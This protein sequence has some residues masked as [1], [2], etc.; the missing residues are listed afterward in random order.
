VAEQA[1]DGFNV[2]V[3][4]TNSGTTDGDEVTQVYISRTGTT[5]PA[6]PLAL[7]AFA[8]TPV[9][10]GK[11]VLLSLTVR[12]A[13]LAVVQP[14][15]RQGWVLQPCEITLYVGGRQPSAPVPEHNPQDVVQVG[16]AH[17]SHA[18]IAF[19]RLIGF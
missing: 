6:P 19:Q 15:G 11:S 16:G 12:A 8:R 13:S 3:L 17:T 10:A 7:A 14:L 9:P 4:L 18:I 1:C 5:A 2:S